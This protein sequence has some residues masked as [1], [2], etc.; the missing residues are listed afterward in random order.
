MTLLFVVFFLLT[1][2]NRGKMYSNIIRA[3]IGGGVSS[4]FLLSLI[5]ICFLPE[6]IVIHP[7]KSHTSSYVLN[8]QF[9]NQFGARYLQNNYEGDLE[10]QA[11]TYSKDSYM[12]KGM[13]VRGSSYHCI[14]LPKGELVRVKSSPDFYFSIPGSV[15]GNI[16]F[17][18]KDEVVWCVTEVG[19]YL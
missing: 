19:K 4:G 5:S 15:E 11:V 7:D 9:F 14:L 6:Y 18:Y 12:P 3:G 13:L 2:H 16:L 8:E 17:K 10:Y 1:N